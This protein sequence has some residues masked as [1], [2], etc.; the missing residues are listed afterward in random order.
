[1]RRQCIVC[2]SRNLIPLYDP[3]PQPLTTLRI[4]QTVADAMCAPKF[5]MHHVLCEDCGH[6][7][8]LQFEEKNVD[9]EQDWQMYNSGIAWK[10]H[11]ERAANEILERAQL[12]DTSTVLEIGSGSGGFM[13]EMI[14][15]PLG[16]RL[17]YRGVDPGVDVSDAEF[18]NEGQD[19][20]IERA[21]ANCE[22][23]IDKHEPSLIIMR[24]VL[25]HFPRP[26][27]FIDELVRACHITQ[28][29]PFV[30]IEVPNG[31]LI[32][33]RLRSQDMMYEHV[34]H[35]TLSSLDVLLRKHFRVVYLKP[36]CRGSML[37]ALVKLRS[38]MS[39]RKRAEGFADQIALQV[40]TVQGQLEFLRT[41]ELDDT[42]NRPLAF[43]GAIGK[44]ASFFNLYQVDKTRYPLVVDS[45]LALV[46]L[47]VPGTG[48]EIKFPIDELVQDPP[49]TII[50][51]SAWR[52]HDIAD[53]IRSIGIN[54]KQ[55][56]YID[57]GQL[58]PYGG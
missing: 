54:C 10:D 42:Y 39:H 44:S 52:I 37:T 33:D 43:W 51:T 56:M 48:Q 32:L 34:S 26:A 13:R 46:E 50:V 20:I 49:R 31:D 36:D 1:M 25:E 41:Q 23:D 35:F 24:H 15:Y 28:V 7:F 47:F 9:Y 8:N 11:F 53:Q 19:I 38:P 17:R 58:V 5:G 16:A 2:E 45:N 14:Q 57:N 4:P 55:I 29:S 22:Y 27:E 12:P 21:F 3:G 40:A 6:I 18:A 30:F